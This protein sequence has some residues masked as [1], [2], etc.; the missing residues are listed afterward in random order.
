MKNLIQSVLILIPVLLS[1]TGAEEVI[2]AQLGD[3]VSF[4]PPVDPQSK[5][6]YLYWYFGNL[7]LA[8][9]NTFG[10]TGFNK[11]NWN[12][13]LSLSDDTLIIKNFQHFGTFVCKLI[14]GRDTVVGSRI[15]KV[16]KL[17]VNMNP[18]N[19]VL[20]DESLSLTCS[21]E[22]PKKPQI[23]WLNPQKEKLKSNQGRLT[24]SATGQHNGQWTCVVTDDGRESKAEVS[25]MVIYLLPPPSR[26]QYTSKSS[27]LTIPCSYPSHIPWE[28]I[29]SK[30]IQQVHWDFLP[31][32]TLN[33]GDPQRLYSLSLEEKPT[34]E[35]DQDRGLNP[36]QNTMKG[37]LSLTRKQ[38]NE[39]DGG[40]YTCTLKFKNGVTLSRTV[41]VNVLQIISSAGTDLISGQQV[42]LSCS[43]GRPLPSELRV[44]WFPPTRSSQPS[45]LSDHHPAHLAIPEVGTGDGGKWRCELWQNNTRLT[46][47]VITLKIEPKT[48]VW[49]L[50]IICSVTA[51]VALLLILALVLCRRR[52]KMRHL[53]HRLCQ[54]KNP[55]P[56]G[57]YRT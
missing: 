48:T 20:L 26:T 8:W 7:E 23:H 46:S 13:T 52:Q 1:T 30:G 39:E 50:V 37:N 11:D 40:D 36:V 27:P 18:P 19:P 15:Y 6:Y 33:S 32:S 42:N 38:G 51:I 55:K 43:I 2:Y 24:L 56:K 34:W 31:G 57:F 45:L 4:K 44:K 3:T 47:A 41:H 14:K 16:L 28:K 5:I 9:R 29:K 17:N 54:C 35:A 21:V 53:R 22:S 49:M 12:N 10:A 25:V